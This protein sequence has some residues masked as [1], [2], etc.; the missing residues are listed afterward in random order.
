MD[1][2]FDSLP[3][4]SIKHKWLVIKLNMFKVFDKFVQR[5]YGVVLMSHIFIGYMGLF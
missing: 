2:L 1:K 3:H 5:V 4:K